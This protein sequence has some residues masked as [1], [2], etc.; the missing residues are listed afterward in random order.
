MK[1]S[2]GILMFRVTNAVPEFFLVH[3][4]GPFFK[5]KDEG[6]WTIPKGEYNDE[7][8]ALSAAKREFFE[9]TGIDVA[10]PFIQLTPIRQKSGKWVSAWAVQGDIDPDKVRS[11]KFTI[12]WPPKSNK[13]REFPE[14]DRA[15]W[16]AR[17]EALLKLNPA[18]TAFVDELTSIIHSR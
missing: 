1:R 15:G 8:E 18:Q 16:F 5:N 9:E 2:A 12:E 17:E 3:P 6:V 11:N 4:G 7:E 10:G 13:L 14:I